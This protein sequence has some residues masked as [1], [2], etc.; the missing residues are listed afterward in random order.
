[1]PV[2]RRM[3]G[4]IFK[5][6]VDATLGVPNLL[7]ETCSVRPSGFAEAKKMLYPASLTIV[8]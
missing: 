5:R 6:F 7:D 8:K 1:M 2:Y 3:Q 4:I